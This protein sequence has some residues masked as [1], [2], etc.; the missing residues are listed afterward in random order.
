M[1]KD[2]V[3]II[4]GGS[5]GIGKAAAIRLARQ[6]CNIAIVFQ[7]KEQVAQQTAAEIKAFGVNVKTYK[8]KV[9]CSDDVKQM[10]ADV[11]A[12]FGTIDILINCA[13]IIRDGLL[14]GMPDQDFDKVI[15]VNLKGTFNTIKHAGIVLMRKKWGRII[16][17]SSVSGMMG[18]SGQ[19]NYAASKAGVIG[20]TKT[21]ARELAAR[22]ITCN[23]I[24][25]G[26]IQTD[27]TGSLDSQ[28]LEDGLKNIPMRRIGQADEVAALIEFLVSD[29]AA[30]IT[31]EVIKVD[32]GM[33]I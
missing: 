27:M 12:D 8:C 5:R 10:V 4:T 3:A 16:N 9:E 23:A 14:L 31:G 26:F 19:A 22:N 28:V 1:F 32:G 29:N 30:Y 11:V 17:I 6:G 33:Y 7:G 25:P 13:G 20:L 15:D 2:K 18:N 24:A 21:A